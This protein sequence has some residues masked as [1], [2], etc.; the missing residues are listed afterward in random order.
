MNLVRAYCR[1]DAAPSN[2]IRPLNIIWEMTMN[3][4]ETNAGYIAAEEHMGMLSRD[5]LYEGETLEIRPAAAGENTGGYE[6]VKRVEGTI[7][8]IV[9]FDPKGQQIW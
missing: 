2:P 3:T 1:P 8:D 6:V 9:A 7:E 5:G 4:D